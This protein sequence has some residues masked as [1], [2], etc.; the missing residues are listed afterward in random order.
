[1][2]LVLEASKLLIMAK[3]IKH[4]CPIVVV[5][6]FSIYS[7]FHYPIASGV[8]SKAPIPLISLKYQ[9]LKVV[10]PSLLTS[11]PSLTYTLIGSW[12]KLTL[13]MFL[14]TF[15]KLLFL[16]SC[17]MLGDLWQASSP[18]PSFFR[19]SFFSL[20]LA[21]VAWEEVHHYWVFFKQ[22]VK[23]PLKR[24][25]ICLGPLLRILKNHYANPQLCFSIPSRQY[26][27][28]GPY[29]RNCLCL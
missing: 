9:P 3:D 23:W 19:C 4:L 12:C 25:F 21:W 13:K 29:E 6:F 20:I 2:A 11:R 24:Y 5:K 17:K 7:S 10:K 16:E 18:L 1:M 28:C 15:F 14:I 8:V 22:E 27:H 26:T